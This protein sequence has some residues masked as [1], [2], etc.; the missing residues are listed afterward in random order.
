MWKNNYSE[1][2]DYF[3]KMTLKEYKTFDKTVGSYLIDND[4]ETSIDYLYLHNKE[5]KNLHII[6]SG[7]HGVEGYPGSAIQFQTLENLS[8]DETSY[9]II[10][11]LNPYGFKNNRR[12]TKNN[13]DLNRNYLESNNF[14]DDSYPRIIFDLISTFLYSLQFIYLFFYILYQYGWTKSREYIVKGQ[15]AYKNGL[16]YGG[17]SR[18]ENIDVLEK[19]LYIVDYSKFDDIYIFDIH[20]G[21]GKYGNLSVMVIEDKTIQKLHTLDFNSTTQLVNMSIDNIYKESKGSIIEGVYNYI[22][23]KDPDKN[24]YPIILEYGTYSNIRLFHRLLLENYYF[25]NKNNAIEW[26]RASKNLKSMFYVEN[27]VWK[28]LVINNYKDFIKLLHL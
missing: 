16:F 11:G 10:H 17:E 20:S 22:I 28:N 8:G 3:K 27:D 4:K 5:S 2:R 7:T 23:N 26:G 25:C 6:I 13:I 9:L 14:K 18:E 21:L 19:I 24:V 1:S 12:C 15:Y